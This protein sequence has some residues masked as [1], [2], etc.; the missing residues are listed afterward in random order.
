MVTDPAGQ[1]YKYDYDALG[2][3]TAKKQVIDGNDMTLEQYEYHYKQ[4]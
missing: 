1:I 2:R 3:L 4:D